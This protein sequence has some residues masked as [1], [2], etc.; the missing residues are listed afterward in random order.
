[1]ELLQLHYFRKVAELEHMTKAA[2]ELRIA[3]PALSKT[4]ARLEADLGVPL[5]DRQGRNIRLNSFGKAYLKKVETALMTLED[6]RREVKDLAGMERGRIILATTSH[7]CFSDIIGSFISSNPDVKLQ[8]IQAS[9]KE[10]V[11]QLQSGDIDFCITF[12]PI[13]QTGIE[14]I[15]FL[16]EKIL[17][18][19]PHTHRFAKRSSID[20]SEVA[21]DPFIFIKQGNPFRDMTDEFCRKAG[22]TPNIV[23]EVDE[24]SAIIHFLRTGI[25]VAF[26]PETLMENTDIS[27][28]SMEIHRPVCQRT[29]QIAWLK[30]RYMS[31][32]ARKFRD[33]VV[34][35]FNELPQRQN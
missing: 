22:F 13:K 4:I 17:L 33:F 15:S 9:E 24:H 29:Y 1:M 31:K 6:G 32:V 28:H 5:F 12:P 21:D 3:Q 7:K 11:Q 35:S 16:T 10:K 30:N 25:G 2:R 26:L 19:V 14:G 20:L 8:I 27:F 18:A 34:Q 23:C